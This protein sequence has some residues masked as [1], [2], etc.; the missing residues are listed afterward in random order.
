MNL[1]NLLWLLV[2]AHVIADFF[3]QTNR[4]VKE[5][6]DKKI[7]SFSL[8]YHTFSAGVLSY[9][10]FMLCGIY[11]EWLIPLI[12]AGSHFLIDLGKTYCK[13]NI[14]PLFLTDQFLHLL[15]ILLCWLGYTGQWEA[16]ASLTASIFSHY[17]II[18]ITVAYLIITKPVSVVVGLVVSRW[19]HAI[20]TNSADEAK[21]LEKAGEWIGYLERILI[22]TFIL[23]SYYEG[24]GFLFA[25]KSIFRFGEL[26]KSKE[27]ALTEYILVGTLLSFT[28]AIATGVLLQILI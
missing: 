6:D 5:R 17:R 26:T 27:R 4:D 15:V 23:M 11:T 12:I 14:L 20:R 19:E 2:A 1:M 9:L 7:R 8:Y 16:F 25:A 24:I 21:G 22:L 13:R 18:A 28:L 3:L 10:A